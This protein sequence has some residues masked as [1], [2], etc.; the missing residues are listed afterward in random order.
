MLRGSNGERRIVND[1]IGQPISIDDLKPTVPGKTMEL[2][3]DAALQDQ[4]ERVL[5]GVGKHVLAQ[6]RD[7]DRR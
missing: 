2:T 4:V 3:I 1:A 6:G 7:R 5:A